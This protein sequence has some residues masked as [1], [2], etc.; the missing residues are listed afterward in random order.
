MT[1]RMIDLKRVDF[2]ARKKPLP[3]GTV[4]PSAEIASPLFHA[5]DVTEQLREP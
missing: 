5:L 2:T 4:A 1:W 3:T